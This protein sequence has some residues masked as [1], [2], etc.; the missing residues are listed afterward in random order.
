MKCFDFLVLVFLGIASRYFDL[1][2][3]ER[4]RRLHVGVQ[5]VER[6][7][8][9][10][11]AAHRTKPTD[12]SQNEQRNY[13]EKVRNLVSFSQGSLRKFARWIRGT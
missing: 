6:G 13:Q 11:A 1:L 12:G 10:A 3:A 7:R 9:H 4:V 2:L 5:R 8:R